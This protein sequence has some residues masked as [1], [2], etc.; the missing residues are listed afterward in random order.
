MDSKRIEDIQKTL[1]GYPDSISVS[2]ALLTVWNECEQSFDRKEFNR[3]QWREQALSAAC[4]V[5]QA[6]KEGLR[7]EVERRGADAQQCREQNDCLVSEHL[8]LRR[9]IK[10][11]QTMEHLQDG[12]IADLKAE[13]KR[14]MD[15]PRKPH[16]VM[17]VE[18]KHEH[19]A[20]EV[21]QLRKQVE[22]LKAAT[23]MQSAQLNDRGEQIRDLKRANSDLA[24]AAIAPQSVADLMGERD[25]LRV[26]LRQAADENTRLNADLAGRLT[27]ERELKE[28]IDRWKA[29]YTAQKEETSRLMMRY[30]E[31]KDRIAA[32]LV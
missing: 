7:A 27:A 23:A 9:E 11:L 1:T 19:L 26:E 17:M 24:T 4:E 18:A 5:H 21:L 30:I 8:D 29:R 28:E 31:V 6:E 22:G 14:L 20:T 12:V 10:K 2:Q 25:L 16:P 3:L 32:A 13:N 15:D